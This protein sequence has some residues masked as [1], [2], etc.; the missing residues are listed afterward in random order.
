MDDTFFTKE[1]LKTQICEWID[2]NEYATDTVGFVLHLVYKGRES[3]GTLE[4]C[5]S[6]RDVINFAAHLLNN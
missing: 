3:G 6:H 5:I 4:E 1:E 2:N